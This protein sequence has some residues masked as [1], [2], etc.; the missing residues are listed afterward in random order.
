MPNYCDNRITITRG[1]LRIVAFFDCEEDLK[2]GC[3]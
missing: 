3:Y 1:D 2:A